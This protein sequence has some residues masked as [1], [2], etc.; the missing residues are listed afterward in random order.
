[1]D[2]V[3]AEKLALTLMEE[4][5][6]LPA[7]RFE[8][9][10]ARKRFGRC[11]YNKKVISL[12]RHLAKINPRR[13]VEETIRHE[14]AHAKDAE[15]RGLSDHS[16]HWKRWAL[17]C[18]AKPVRCYSPSQINTPEAPL[19]TFC[20]NCKQYIPRYRKSKTAR[21]YTCGRCSGSYNPDYAVIPNI[22]LSKKK[23]IETGQ[24]KWQ[25]LPQ[26]GTVAK[27]LEK[28]EVNTLFLRKYKEESQ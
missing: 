19:Y 2:L 22:P 1:M 7:W 5:E 13:N 15:E 14:I 23:R 20:P 26:T 9:D 18:G 10:N 6:L 25:D 12:S 17:R 8:W 28:N 24:L 11:S 16:N 4:F 3:E 21:I 27:N